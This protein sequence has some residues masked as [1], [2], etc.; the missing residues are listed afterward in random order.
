MKTEAFSII[1]L[2]LVGAA[3]T[4]G[5]VPELFEP[6]VWK[7]PETPLQGLREII[8]ALPAA[9]REIRP[10]TELA[11]QPKVVTTAKAGQLVI[12]GPTPDVED[13]LMVRLENHGSQPPYITGGVTFDRDDKSEHFFVGRQATGAWATKQVLNPGDGF[14]FN[15]AMED[16]CFTRLTRTGPRGSRRR[17]RRCAGARC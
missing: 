3:G 17:R 5:K 16:P 7:T 8:R 4:T 9:F 10:V 15:I 11:A 6:Y 12:P 13:V 2:V 14:T 1:T